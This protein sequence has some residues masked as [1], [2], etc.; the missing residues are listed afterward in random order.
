MQGTEHLLGVRPTTE[1][2]RVTPCTAYR[3]NR[4]TEH[5]LGVRPTTEASR[6]TPR[7]VTCVMGMGNVCVWA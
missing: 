7:T 2:S 1:A 3:L 6:V 4:G 5:L